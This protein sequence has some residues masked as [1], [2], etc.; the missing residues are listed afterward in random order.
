MSRR[1]NLLLAI[2]LATSTARA[3]ADIKDNLIDFGVKGSWCWF[4]DERAI[5]DNGRL[6]FGSVACPSGD[7]NVTAYDLTT[8][9]ARTVCLHQK[10]Q[11]DDHDTPAFLKLKDGRY[12]AS[13][14]SHGG[15]KGVAGLDLM[16][17]RISNNPGDP[18]EWQPEQTVSVGAGVS[19]TNLYRLSAENDRIYN[20]HRGFGF[21][22]NYLIS[23]DDGQ[24]FKYGGRTMTWNAI[25][26]QTGS[27]RP[28]VRYASNN[29]DT[30]HF[31]NTED[32][33]RNVDNSIYHGFIK[34]GKMHKSDGTIVGDPSTAKTSPIKPTD[35]TCVYKGDADHVA[36]TTDLR[37]DS[38][39][40]PHIIFSVR[41]NDR[42]VRKFYDK[43][44]EDLR[45]HYGRWDG[46][47]WATSEIAFAGNRLY[48]GEMDYTGL[49]ALHPADPDILYIS[50]NADPKTG[51]PLISSAGHARHREIF[52]GVTK[53]AGKTFEW[54][55]VTSN[56][57]ADNLRPIAR[58]IDGRK[59]VVIWLRGVYSSYTKYDVKVVGII[60]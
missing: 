35:F 49:A 3:A 6:I 37:L 4:Q 29:I 7:V 27:G 1:L 41:M 38:A 19:Y 5:I 55:A 53:D 60:D 18:T 40:R 12:L 10:F 51:Q 9:T 8:K 57:S 42:E 21:N 16:R 20:F 52:K 2:L 17:W 56:S 26:G 46:A 44:G 28:Y 43:G 23:D 13:F 39:G 34:T 47:K 50:T 15:G 36:W 59:A 25:P 24:T 32:H 48:V 11:S 33:P 14:M 22:P 58:V 30:V 45:F 31:I 54:T